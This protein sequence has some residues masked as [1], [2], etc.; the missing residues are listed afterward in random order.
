MLW[1]LGLAVSMQV[2]LMF[3]SAFV[4]LLF[5]LDFISQSFSSYCGSIFELNTGMSFWGQGRIRTA[6]KWCESNSVWLE[7][8]KLSESIYRNCCWRW[9]WASSR[10]KSRQGIKKDFWNSVEVPWKEIPKILWGTHLWERKEKVIPKKIFPLRHHLFDLPF[11]KS[12]NF[13]HCSF[14]LV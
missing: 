4:A 13:H 9:W 6:K 5:S 11:L 10:L 1:F 8:A 3:T 7:Q 14:Y 12:C 2:K